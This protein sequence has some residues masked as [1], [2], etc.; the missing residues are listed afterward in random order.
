[1]IERWSAKAI[2]TF[3]QLSNMPRAKSVANWYTALALIK[4]NQFEEAA[5]ILRQFSNGQLVTTG[6]RKEQAR[7]I[8]ESLKE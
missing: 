7:K 2:K 1:M 3:Q 6:K 8:L 5:A 4:D